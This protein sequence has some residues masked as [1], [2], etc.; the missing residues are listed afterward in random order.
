MLY[1]YISPMGHFRKAFRVYSRLVHGASANIT[2]GPSLPSDCTEILIQGLIRGSA[3]I[4]KQAVERGIDYYL[5]DHAY[6]DSGYD[7]MP[8]N[9]RISKNGMVQS[10]LVPNYKNVVVPSKY[11]NVKMKT[12]GTKILILPPTEPVELFTGEF[13]WLEN[14]LKILEPQVAD[15]EFT[16]HVCEKDRK[17]IMDPSGQIAGRVDINTESV[18]DLIDDAY[19]VI[20]FNSVEAVH[21]ALKGVP[22]IATKHCPAYPISNDITDIHNLELGD[23]EGLYVSLRNGQFSEIEMYQN[24]VI[25]NLRKITQNDNS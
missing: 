20:A 8:N 11:K 12:G 15:T 23:V 7:N 13:N 18:H 24:Q 1:A 16:I 19:C 4:K 25:P 10:L 21:S 3:E 9:M 5:M 6:F 14:T 2:N 22:V 17:I